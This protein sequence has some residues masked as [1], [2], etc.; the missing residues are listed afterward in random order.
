MIRRR[1]PAAARQSAGE[2]EVAG[3]VPGL[4]DAVLAVPA[5]HGERAG[6]QAEQAPEWGLQPDPARRED[7][8]QV[9]VR[10]QEDVAVGVAAPVRGPGPPG[11]RPRPPSRRP[12]RG[13]SRWTSRDRSRGCPA[14]ASL[15]ARRSPTRR[16]PVRPRAVPKPASAAVSLA[17]TRGLV[18]TRLNGGRPSSARPRSRAPSARACS[19]PASVSGMSVRPVWRPSSAHSVCPCRTSQIRGPFD[20]VAVAHADVSST[21]GRTVSA[22]SASKNSRGPHRKS[23]ART[24]AGTVAIFVL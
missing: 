5:E 19:R 6:R 20:V 16:G 24:I 2:L 13:R 17:R 10:E 3:L 11:A 12:A 9:T 18:R 8:E 22:G 7:A 14:S 15:R 21:S 23:H 4:D 1:C